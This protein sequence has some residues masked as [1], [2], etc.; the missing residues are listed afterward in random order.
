[1]VQLNLLCLQTQH[2]EFHFLSSVK[3]QLD[4]PHEITT[5][6]Y[7]AQISAKRAAWLRGHATREPDYTPDPSPALTAK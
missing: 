2:E 7:M 4:C 6:P 5:S 1:M 3:E